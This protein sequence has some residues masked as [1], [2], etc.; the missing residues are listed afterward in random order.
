MQARYCGVHTAALAPCG[1]RA[2]CKDANRPQSYYIHLALVGHSP[3]AACCSSQTE[4]QCC[5]TTCLIHSGGCGVNMVST[6]ISREACQNCSLVPQATSP[7]IYTPTVVT[8]QI[9]WPLH[10]SAYHTSQSYRICRVRRVHTA[11]LSQASYGCVSLVA[12]PV[13]RCRGNRSTVA[14]QD[15]QHSPALER[16]KQA[17]SLH[18]VR[19]F[20]QKVVERQLC[21]KRV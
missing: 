1:A 4:S 19:E 13:F 14:L 18:T 3:G 2:L 21:A 9:R 15:L 11:P 20:L 8:S 12:S 16:H 7:N 17:T 5:A 10:L 6:E